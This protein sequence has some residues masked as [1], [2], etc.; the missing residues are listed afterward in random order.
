MLRFSIKFMVFCEFALCH[1]HLLCALYHWTSL[2]HILCASKDIEFTLPHIQ[3]CTLQH[4]TWMLPH[5]LL[6]HTTNMV[7]HIHAIFLAV[8]VS[9]CVCVP[10][11]VCMSIC[12][13]MSMCICGWVAMNPNIYIKRSAC[14][15]VMAYAYYSCELGVWQQRQKH[16]PK[17]VHCSKMWQDYQDWYLE[18][19]SS[20]VSINLQDLVAKLGGTKSQKRL[21]LVC[22]NQNWSLQQ[23]CGKITKFVFWMQDQLGFYWQTRFGSQT[24]WNQKPKV[25]D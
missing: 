22:G 1:S 25:L 5:V 8:T 15:S 6:Q 13:C 4:N 9:M 23:K 10:I 2:T 7:T 16:K 14:V 20:F 3:L 19:S 17:L 24:W 12:I 18:C 11:C 21:V